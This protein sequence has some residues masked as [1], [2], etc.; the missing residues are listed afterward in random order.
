MFDFDI[1]LRC[2]QWI[3]GCKHVLLVGVI[4]V[5]GKQVLWSA[6]NA[7]GVDVGDVECSSSCHAAQKLGRACNLYVRN[8]G[9]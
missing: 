7:V 8:V 4:A 6:N 2:G 5:D 3:V 1:F 9:P